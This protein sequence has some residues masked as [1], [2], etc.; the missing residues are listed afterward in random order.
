MPHAFNDSG[1]IVGTLGTVI[2][3]LLCVSYISRLAILRGTKT[4]KVVYI[5]SKT[6]HRARC[7]RLIYKRLLFPLGN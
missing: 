6:F 2:I 7:T 4:T 1:Y 5:I 3:G